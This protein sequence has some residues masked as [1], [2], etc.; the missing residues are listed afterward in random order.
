MCVCW[1]R[2]VGVGKEEAWLTGEEGGDRGGVKGQRGVGGLKAAFK[3]KSGEGV[4]I[5]MVRK[6]EG[7]R[8]RWG[9]NHG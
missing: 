2:R 7:L 1:V 3:E 9:L 6:K 4:E 8:R 5:N